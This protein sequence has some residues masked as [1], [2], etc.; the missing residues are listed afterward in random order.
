[1]PVTNTQEVFDIRSI[2]PTLINPS[3]MEGEKL[4][5]SLFGPMSAKEI[6]R[7][8]PSNLT[9]PT[10]SGNTRIPSILI[11]DPGAWL[12]SPTPDF[13]FQWYSAGVLIPGAVGATYL[14]DFAYDD[15][16]IT[17]EVTATNVLDSAT[18]M[19][20]NGILI[21]LIETL[22]VQG[23]GY[24]TVTGLGA[25]DQIE[26]YF[27]RNYVITGLW[28][29]DQISTSTHSV[30]MITGFWVEDRMDFEEHHV[31]VLN[32]LASK[33]RL[34]VYE[35]ETYAMS[36]LLYERAL[37]LTN[38]GADLGNTSG[39]TTLVGTPAVRTGGIG[40]QSGSHY[41]TGGTAVVSTMYQ[42]V[43][44]PGDLEAS[45][46]GSLSYI[47]RSYYHT[48]FQNLGGTD[49]GTVYL[50]FFN[51]SMMSLGI[52]FNSYHYPL[53]DR[54]DL[55]FDYPVLVPVSTR[56]VR[57][58]VRLDKVNGVNN[59]GYVDSISVDLWKET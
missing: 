37:T 38:P 35:F 48:T 14:S 42:D 40:P 10:V 32:G 1:M 24:Y 28:V 7:F 41:F 57:V 26:T 18:M 29:E 15:T 8:P 16:T 23:Q 46:D 31:M 6:I 44:I 2:R 4:T 43:A 39:W 49:Y 11:C 51:A 22:N 13:S 17:C 53:D 59:D 3:I 27:I 56:F 5:S 47:S 54:W 33:E 36:Y 52:A 30:N 55:V 12:G 45:V 58:F 21:N 19:S 50:E 9:P 25:E 20:S 34:E